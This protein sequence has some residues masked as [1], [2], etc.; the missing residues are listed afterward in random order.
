MEKFELS[1]KDLKDIEARLKEGK[2]KLEKLVME[3]P[4]TSVVVA[5]FLGYLISKV[6]NS[7]D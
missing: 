4:T 6:F 7:K 3:H 1:E 5:F 2:T